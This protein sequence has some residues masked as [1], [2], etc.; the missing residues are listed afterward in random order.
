MTAADWRLTGAVA[1]LIAAILTAVTWCA[2]VPH[3]SPAQRLGWVGAYERV[4]SAGRR[5]CAEHGQTDCNAAWL[6]AHAAEH[7]R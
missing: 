6:E 3:E 4:T 2:P 7:G 5:M 1:V